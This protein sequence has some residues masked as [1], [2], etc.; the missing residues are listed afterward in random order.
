MSTL[1]M[2]ARLLTGVGLGAVIGFE[3][4]YRS[5]M[6]GL[7]TIVSQV[8]I[9]GSPRSSA[10]RMGLGWGAELMIVSSFFATCVMVGC[11]STIVDTWRTVRLWP[12]SGQGQENADDG[13]GSMSPDIGGHDDIIDGRRQVRVGGLPPIGWGKSPNPQDLPK[14]RASVE[15]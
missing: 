13:N 12:R 4:Q 15:S 3:R 9:C 1:E 11:H 6:A 2:L 5:R 7:R 14:P 10:A 8:P